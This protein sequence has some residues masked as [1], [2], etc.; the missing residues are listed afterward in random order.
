MGI[1]FLDLFFLAL[2]IHIMSDN[3]I[4]KINYMQADISFFYFLCTL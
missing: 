4:A 2:E 3:K 1:S